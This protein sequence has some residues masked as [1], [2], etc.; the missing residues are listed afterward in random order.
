MAVNFDSEPHREYLKHINTHV[1][2]VQQKLQSITAHLDRQQQFFSQQLRLLSLS[3]WNKCNPGHGNPG[4]SFLAASAAF[5]CPSAWGPRRRRFSAGP[6]RRRGWTS[7]V[8]AVCL[9]LDYGEATAPLSFCS[10]NGHW[11]L[12]IAIEVLGFCHSG[13]F[14][15]GC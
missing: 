2:D 6:S 12:S 11:L 4:T 8:Q 13:F 9:R 15:D 14:E 1:E 3:I 10:R 7:A 5:R